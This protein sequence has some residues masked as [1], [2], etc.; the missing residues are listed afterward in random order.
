MPKHV[1]WIG[2]AQRRDQTLVF[3]GDEAKHAVRVKRLRV[4]EDVLG[5]DGCGTLVRGEVVSLGRELVIGIV[6]TTEEF[7]PSPTIE[8]WA[9]TPK[10]TR[11]GDLVDTLT[12]VGAQSWI[13]MTTNRSVSSLTAAK[14]ARLGRVAIEA[15][16]QSRRAWLLEIAPEASF[17]QALRSDDAVLV[18]ADQAGEPITG[19]QADR[20][21]LL[22]GPEGG[23]TEEDLAQAKE[24]GARSCSFG[25]HVMRI[26]VAATIGCAAL[27]GSGR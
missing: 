5:L 8:V 2:D 17:A 12:Q 21:R 14:R 10:G 27:V 3:T 24:A 26:E 19:L 25:P 13:P 1:L 22:I 15:C 4:G 9:P 18:I 23:F 11:S 16:K 20:V 7:P 6:E